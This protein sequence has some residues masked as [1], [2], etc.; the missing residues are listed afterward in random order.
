[1]SKKI[2]LKLVSAYFQL[3]R[4]ARLRYRPEGLPRPLGGV[5]ARRRRGRQLGRVLGAQPAEGAAGAGGLLGAAPGVG[6][7]GRAGAGGAAV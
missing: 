2:A 7:G 5:A 1:M 6:G 4:T 3:N